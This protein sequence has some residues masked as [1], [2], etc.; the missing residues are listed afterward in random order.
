MIT[1]HAGADS[2]P[3]YRRDGRLESPLLWRSHRT[4]NEL[5]WCSTRENCAHLMHCCKTLLFVM[6]VIKVILSQCI[7]MISGYYFGMR[8]KLMQTNQLLASIWRTA[9]NSSLPKPNN[10]LYLLNQHQKDSAS[11]FGAIIAVKI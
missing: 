3:A 4:V 8:Y 10:P 1:I 6:L 2:M 7:A 11:N 5:N 9:I